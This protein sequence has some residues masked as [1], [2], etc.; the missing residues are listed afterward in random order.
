MAGIRI[1][2]DSTLSPQEL[3]TEAKKRNTP[4]RQDAFIEDSDSDVKVSS[5][6]QQEQELSNLI[7][8]SALAQGVLRIYLAKPDKQYLVFKDQAS[9]DQFVN[10]L[11]LGNYKVV[12][13]KNSA[14]DYRIAGQENTLE[15]PASSKLIEKG[16]VVRITEEE[17]QTI[18]QAYNNYRKDFP[19][20]D[21]VR[22]RELQQQLNDMTE[23]FGFLKE[24]GI[25]TPELRQK[26]IEKTKKFFHERP[27]MG[28]VNNPI[29]RFLAYL[30]RKG[31]LNKDIAE[32]VILYGDVN[33]YVGYLAGCCK[34]LIELSERGWAT[35][36]NIKL[37]VS[38]L[39]SGHGNEEKN[40]SDRVMAL[41]EFL[42]QQE[43]A[44]KKVTW[45][46]N[47]LQD[48]LDII[49]FSER[50]DD[51]IASTQMAEIYRQLREAK[52]ITSES[53]KYLFDEAHVAQMREILQN[54]WKDNSSNLDTK[55]NEKRIRENM[56]YL[57][58]L[59]NFA[60]QIWGLYL[61]DLTSLLTQE[62]FDKLLVLAPYL[63]L[64]EPAHQHFHRDFRG[65][66]NKLLRKIYSTHIKTV[67]E[68]MLVLHQG[69]RD[70]REQ[71]QKTC[72][73]V[74]D[75]ELIE[76]IFSFLIKLSP[77]NQKI[78]NAKVAN[79]HDLYILA[80]PVASSAPRVSDASSG[81]SSMCVSQLPFSM[82]AGGDV[83]DV[84]HR[85]KMIGSASSASLASVSLASA[86]S[87]DRVVVF[88]VKKE[89][90]ALTLAQ[91]LMVDELFKSINA[92][93]PHPESK[94]E[95]EALRNIQKELNEYCSEL[96]NY[97]YIHDVPDVCDLIGNLRTKVSHAI[98]MFGPKGQSPNNKWHNNLKRID[99]ILK[100]Q[101]NEVNQFFA[102]QCRVQ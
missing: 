37:V 29:Y 4:E 78:F 36:Q 71:E 16:L 27:D 9:F 51:C 43:K 102:P 12:D 26:Y 88:G 77:E 8:Q 74:I 86:S 57:P 99:E 28:D 21:H 31:K 93:F 7:N 17:K 10:R 40:P 52:E 73:Y 13:D 20:P 75:N 38:R 32:I 92:D 22:N 24:L 89:E 101:L 50:R 2:L 58:E 80:H 72:A 19:E 60:N 68:Q 54:R 25:L 84:K 62:V 61:D 3:T 96:D 85:G 45:D 91:Q 35:P 63:H 41:I 30:K 6:S 48:G 53:M 95:R 100:K 64:Y 14:G 47:V 79:F 46:Y 55:E 23:T 44:G 1:S 56:Q 59:M 42:K 81:L 82:F 66:L 98:E 5:Q 65:D 90:Q 49:T 18:C 94:D 33:T 39:H 15:I 87:G 67:A 11:K 70:P 97:Q 76:L 69:Q 34:T 83:K